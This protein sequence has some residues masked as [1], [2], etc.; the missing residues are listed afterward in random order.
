VLLAREAA[1]ATGARRVVIAGTGLA[2]PAGAASAV[3]AALAGGPRPEVAFGDGEAARRA[4]DGVHFSDV[5][6]LWIGGEACPSAIAFVL[7]ADAVRSGRVR[8]ALAVAA[9]GDSATCAVLVAAQEAEGVGG[10]R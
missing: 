3:R 10:E 7:A 2:G 4:V 1:G 5:G 6:A 9:G 8:A